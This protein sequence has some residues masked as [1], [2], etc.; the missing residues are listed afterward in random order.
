MVSLSI[1][2]HPTFST[3]PPFGRPA[4]RRRWTFGVPSLHPGGFSRTNFI[5]GSAGYRT[6]YSS[7]P[8]SRSR[9]PSSA[10]GNAAVG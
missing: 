10:W 9:F 6:R 4:M 2:F 5:N 8:R 7:G 1:S 3:S